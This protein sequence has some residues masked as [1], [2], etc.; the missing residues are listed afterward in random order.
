MVKVELVTDKH[1]SGP[2]VDKGGEN[3]RRFAK[4]GVED[5]RLSELQAELQ[6]S[7]EMV[8]G[9]DWGGDI[10]GDGLWVLCGLAVKVEGE[11]PPIDAGVGGV[12]PGE[13]Q[14]EGGR[15]VQMGHK[16]P[17]I[18]PLTVGEGEGGLH[19]VSDVIGGGGAAVKEGEVDGKG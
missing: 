13:A 6:G 8:G 18:L 17:E 2:A 4:S 7:V 19:V 16:Q 9:A 15:G 12:E 14:D 3:L 11:V 5:K 10:E 1:P